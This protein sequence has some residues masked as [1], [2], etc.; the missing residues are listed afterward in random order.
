[1][2]RK[3]AQ[4]FCRQSRR[5]EGEYREYSTNEQRRVTA[6]DQAAFPELLFDASLV[7]G[8]N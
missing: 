7:K 2:S 3:D 6:K 4:G 5:E 1:M 8:S